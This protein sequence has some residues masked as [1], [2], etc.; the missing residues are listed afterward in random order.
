MNKRIRELYEK[1]YYWFDPKFGP[2]IL[3]IVPACYLYLIFDF[4]FD[5]CYNAYKRVKRLFQKRDI[6]ELKK[7]SGIKK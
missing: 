2:H 3:W 7:L 1:I 6:K 5:C 4:I